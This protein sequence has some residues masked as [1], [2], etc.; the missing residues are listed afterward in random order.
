MRLARV[1]LIVI[2]YKSST[3]PSMHHH[4]MWQNL[5]GPAMW[6]SKCGPP[7]MLILQLGA[8]E[9]DGDVAPHH[10]PTK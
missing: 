8:Y 5:S 2:L 9:L 7:N 4:A 3:G 6:R 1:S 10:S